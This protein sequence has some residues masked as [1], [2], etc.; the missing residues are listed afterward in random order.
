MFET[1]LATAEIGIAWQIKDV[2]DELGDR[3]TSNPEEDGLPVLNQVQAMSLQ[4][5]ASE[6]ERCRQYQT[7]FANSPD[8]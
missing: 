3:V 4:I 5:L 1:Y 2:L 6:R 8:L 7:L